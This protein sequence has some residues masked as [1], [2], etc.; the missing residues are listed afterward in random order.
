M[1]VSLAISIRWRQR[2]FRHL[3][4]ICIDLIFIFHEPHFRS[5]SCIEGTQHTHCISN[6]ALHCTLTPSFNFNSAQSCI[7]VT[8]TG[9][10]ALL[11]FSSN[12]FLQPCLTTWLAYGCRHHAGA[13][14]LIF[15]LLGYSCRMIVWHMTGCVVRVVHYGSR[16]AV[17][18]QVIYLRGISIFLG[19]SMSCFCLYAVES[20]AF[21]G[22][23][24]SNARRLLTIT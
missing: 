16:G 24:Q 13:D 11:S 1:L 4:D 5:D 12:S 14:D 2:D 22:L 3:H 19:P 10:A 23:R 17:H 20:Y 9:S 15:F 18:Y 8:A 6:P 7:R 21:E